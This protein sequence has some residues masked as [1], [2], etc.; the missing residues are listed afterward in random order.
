MNTKTAVHYIR[1]HQKNGK[2]F[3]EDITSHELEEAYRQIIK[4]FA[5]GMWHNS[6]DYAPGIGSPVLLVSDDG[7]FVYTGKLK[8]LYEDNITGWFDLDE[9]YD[10]LSTRDGYKWKYISED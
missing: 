5:T 10:G 6:K 9:C 7:E 8:I 3:G 1:F 2:Y 4:E